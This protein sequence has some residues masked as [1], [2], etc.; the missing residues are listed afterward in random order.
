MSRLTPN[1][2]RVRTAFAAPVRP[3]APNGTSG[4]SVWFTVPAQIQ[5]PWILMSALKRPK[6]GAASDSGFA[7]LETMG[8]AWLEQATSCL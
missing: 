6:C 8:D 2:P 7:W 5:T 1:V 3:V 4:P